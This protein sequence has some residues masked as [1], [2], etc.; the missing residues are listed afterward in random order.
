MT[1]DNLRYFAI[2]YCFTKNALTCCFF[3]YFTPDYCYMIFYRE[4]DLRNR[5]MW[6]ATEFVKFLFLTVKIVILPQDSGNR[7]PLSNDHRAQAFTTL[8]IY[9]TALQLYTRQLGGKRVY[10]YI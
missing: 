1:H 10:R 2:L 5:N 8:H 4:T 7:T 6:R 3:V 9:T